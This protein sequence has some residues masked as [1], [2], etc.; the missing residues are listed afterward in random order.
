MKK[1]G[2]PKSAIAAHTEWKKANP[3]RPEEE[4]DRFIQ[5]IQHLLK[6]FLVREFR[7]ACTCILCYPLLVK[8]GKK[9]P[10]PAFLKG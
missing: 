10:H 3:E 9:V 2:R 4:K 5:E 7:K 1:E 8:K 6:A